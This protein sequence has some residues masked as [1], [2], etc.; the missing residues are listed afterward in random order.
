MEKYL[1]AVDSMF[2]NNSEKKKSEPIYDEDGKELKLTFQQICQGILL[3]GSTVGVLTCFVLRGCQEL[4]KHRD[5]ETPK[6]IMKANVDS[7]TNAASTNIL[8]ITR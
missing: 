8:Q 4:K 3:I 7:V 1:K 2:K 6:M 5:A